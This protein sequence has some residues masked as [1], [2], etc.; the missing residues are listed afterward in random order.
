[1]K[2]Y[3]INIHRDAESELRAAFE[4]IRAEAPRN[5]AA[6][7]SGL[8]GAIASL[9]YM[10][11]RCSFAREREELDVDVRQIVFR[12]HRILF[13]IEKGS[14]LVLHIRHARR[15]TLKRIRGSDKT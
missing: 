5:A 9:E 1:M 7:L 15:N 3:R 8:Y 14:V 10:P 6:W 12:S 11:Q 13:T 4:Y 2:R